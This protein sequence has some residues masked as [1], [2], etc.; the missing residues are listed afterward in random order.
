M[1]VGQQARPYVLRSPPLHFLHL[2]QQGLQG[3]PQVE[4]RQDAHRWRL[5]PRL[6]L[7]I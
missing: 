3:A 5:Q 7:M 6:D 4:E 1:G 2:R